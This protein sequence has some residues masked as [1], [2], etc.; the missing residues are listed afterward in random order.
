M[1]LIIAHLTIGFGIAALL[2]LVG[3][4]GYRNAGVLAVVP[5][6]S[7]ARISRRRRVLRRGAVTCVVTSSLFVLL[8]VLLLP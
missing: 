8:T 7:A 6:W 2:A 1:T 3:R 4:W 5:G